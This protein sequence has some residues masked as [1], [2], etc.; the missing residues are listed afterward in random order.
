MNGTAVDKAKSNLI[1]RIV[2]EAKR[3]GVV[4]SDV[5]V[6][7]LG[8]AEDSA[9]PRELE[10]AQSFAQ[11]FDEAYEARITKLIFSVY[12]RDCKSGRKPEWDQWLDEI[13]E[14]ELYLSVMLEKAGLLKTTSSLRLPDWR[15]ILGFIPILIFV[16]LALFVAFTPLAARLIPND[17]LRL[18][19]CLL[20]LSAPF[21][22]Y[23]ISTRPT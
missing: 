18:G 19:L 14:E 2:D 5:E 17:F 16:A 13:A 11:G 9:N 7:M 23:K 12:D 4:L 20:L 21:L 1:G 6:Q 8:F 15:L 3:E 10:A 22:I